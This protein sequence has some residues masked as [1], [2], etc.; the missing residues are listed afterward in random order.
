MASRCELIDRRR[1][2]CRHHRV[3][4]VRQDQDT[5]RSGRAYRV[6]YRHLYEEARRGGSGAVTA[7]RRIAARPVY[8]PDR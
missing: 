1:G 7:P 6:W 8:L 2:A 4:G 5:Q 3:Q